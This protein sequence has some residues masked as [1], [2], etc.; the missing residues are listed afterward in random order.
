MTDHTPPDPPRRYDTMLPGAIML[1]AIEMWHE[2][3]A[4]GTAWWNLAMGTW[5]PEHLHHRGAVH[6]DPH[7]QLVVPDPIESDGERALV[8]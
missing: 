1:P 2:S 5:W 6:H 4:F 3:L 7:H 8:A